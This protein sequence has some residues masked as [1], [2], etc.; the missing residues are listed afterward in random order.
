M[1]DAAASNEIPYVHTVQ[2]RFICCRIATSAALLE[3]NL[4]FDRQRSK[5]NATVRRF[6]GKPRGKCSPLVVY[7]RAL[8]CLH[9][10]DRL[11][12][13]WYCS[14]VGYDARVGTTVSNFKFVADVRARAN[15][16]SA[17]C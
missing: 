10:F 2:S 15:F 16:A 1:R 13:L 12:F 17:G 5:P 8:A 14:A 4:C 7:G 6:R 3:V 9:A 11:V